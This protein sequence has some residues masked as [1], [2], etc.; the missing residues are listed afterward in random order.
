VDNHDADAPFPVPQ[1]ALMSNLNT[2]FTV[3]IRGNSV[4]DDNNP[5]F[6]D[7]GLLTV[8]GRELVDTQLEPARATS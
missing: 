7:A 1:D 5:N 6:K 2:L 3:L 4:V 8:L